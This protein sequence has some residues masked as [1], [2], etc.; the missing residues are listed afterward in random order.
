MD[1]DHQFTTISVAERR[2]QDENTDNT[3]EKDAETSKFS[4]GSDSSANTI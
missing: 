2:L 4:S 3:E 1:H